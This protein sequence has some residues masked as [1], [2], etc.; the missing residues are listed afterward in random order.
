MTTT[1]SVSVLDVINTTVHHGDTHIRVGAKQHL[2]FCCKSKEK[3]YTVMF[4]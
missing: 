1:V 4:K 2:Y 3:F